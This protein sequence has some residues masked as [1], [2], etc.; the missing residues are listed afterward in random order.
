ML[1]TLKV[2]ESKVDASAQLPVAKHTTMMAIGRRQ[3]TER[4]EA[5]LNNMVGL[6]LVDTSYETRIP[7][8]SGMW[9]G[10]FASGPFHCK[11]NGLIRVSS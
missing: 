1:R 2:N 5:G 7:C 11:M 10:G 9:V 3:W 6:N 4:Q 8:C